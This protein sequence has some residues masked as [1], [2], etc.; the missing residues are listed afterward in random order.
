MTERRRS[1]KATV[2]VVGRRNGIKVG[3]DFMPGLARCRWLSGIWLSHLPADWPCPRRS[4]PNLQ[5]D[6]HDVTYPDA[7]KG[8]DC[9][10]SA[11][12]LHSG[13]R[14]LFPVALIR[15]ALLCDRV[16][17]SPGQSMKQ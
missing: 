3:C 8:S 5:A 9:F 1:N 12:H 13:P 16:P 11:S 2:V 7:R 15:I 6:I 17:P 10:C 4:T 14:Q